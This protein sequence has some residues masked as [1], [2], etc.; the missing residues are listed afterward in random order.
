MKLWKRAAGAVKDQNS[1]WIAAVSRRSVYRNP[2][3]EAAIIRATSH[4]ES[5]VDYKNVQRVFTW[6]RTSPTYLKPL[7]LAL[8]A[9]MQ[10]TRSWAVALKGLMLMHGI[11]C[12][13][14]P[15]VQRIGRLLFD[16]SG[17]EDS[18]MSPHKAWGYNAFVRAY[19][20][21]LDQKAALLCARVPQ[22][23]KAPSSASNSFSASTREKPTKMIMMAEL[24]ML[25]ELQ[26]LLD[27]LLQIKPKAEGMRRAGL[28]LE[29][30]D[31]V[32]IEIF[33]VYSKICTL[34]A[35]VLSR[36]YESTKAEASTA[37]N[38]LQQANKQ[39]EALSHFFE[40]CNSLGVLNASEFPKVEQVPA[41]DIEEVE[42]IVKRRVSSDEK[43]LLEISDDVCRKNDDSEWNMDHNRAIVVREMAGPIV[44]HVGQQK[45]LTT[46]VTDKWE[47]FDDDHHLKVHSIINGGFSSNVSNNHH[48]QPYKQEIPDLITF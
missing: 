30:M 38:V 21:F 26:S 46:I 4:D 10:R 5:Y 11:F 24:L 17:F 32:I 20:T 9:R 41:E 44:Q 35:R 25:Q 3:L 7:L 45:F 31:C 29:A 42:R 23:P 43:L 27:L 15:A 48:V 22:G 6:V 39:A 33:D 34:I 18:H 28:V 13:K 14:I 40:F 19:F 37:L 8:S 16:F 2:D 1:I 12:C 47:V 36:V